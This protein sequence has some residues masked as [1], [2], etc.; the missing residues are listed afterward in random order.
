MIFLIWSKIDKDF[1]LKIDDDLV[2]KT[3]LNMIKEWKL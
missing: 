3:G 2:H 1:K